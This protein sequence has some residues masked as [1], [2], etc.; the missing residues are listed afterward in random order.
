MN[1]IDLW[2]KH[3]KLYNVFFLST[4]T[5]GHKIT[6]CKQVWALKYTLQRIFYQYF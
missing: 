4:N 6:E 3:A 1:S 5:H 2:V